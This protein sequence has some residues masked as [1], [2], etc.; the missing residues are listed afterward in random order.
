MTTTALRRPVALSTL[1]T[2]LARVTGAIGGLLAARLLGPAGRGEYALLILAGTAAG[3]MGTGGLQFWATGRLGRGDRSQIRAV[4]ERHALRA[5]GLTVLV[6]FVAVLLGASATT[7]TA[8]VAFAIAWTVSVL[9]LAVPNGELDMGTVAAATTAGGA[10][11]I[12]WMVLLDVLGARS[13]AAVVSGAAA[14]NAVVVPL[15][16]RHFRRLPI[17]AGEGYRAAMGLGWSPLV[18]ELVTLGMFRVDIALVAL[19]INNRAAGLYAV[20][21]ALTELLWLVPDGVTLVVLPAASGGQRS[22]ARRLTLIAAGVTACGALLLSLAARPLIVA[23][24]GHVYASASSAVPALAV[25]AVAI[26]MWKMAAADAV[27]SGRGRLRAVSSVVGLVVMLTADAV[28]I[29]WLGIGGAG[30]GAALGYGA[31]AAYVV[32]EWRR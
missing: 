28:L 16:I 14:A 26:G 15:T 13:V 10:L 20:A 11:F 25:A 23:L 24:F 9:W 17:D 29:P 32:R 3:T 30:V 27:A 22:E 8:T 21:T 2:G 31:A 5:A 4:L 1:G 6:G 19:M 12:A 18:S 7:T